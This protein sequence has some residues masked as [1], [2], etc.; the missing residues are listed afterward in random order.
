MNLLAL[1]T[2]RGDLME[3][4]YDESPFL[5]NDSGN[6]VSSPVRNGRENNSKNRNYTTQN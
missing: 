1:Q 6:L 5:K 3:R 2:E 4:R